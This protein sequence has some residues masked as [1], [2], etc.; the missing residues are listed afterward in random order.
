MWAEVTWSEMVVGRDRQYPLGNM[1]LFCTNWVAVYIYR[2]KA[3]DIQWFYGFELYL[4]IS[5]EGH[6]M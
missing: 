3:F 2:V 1:F 6:G 5:P 4:D